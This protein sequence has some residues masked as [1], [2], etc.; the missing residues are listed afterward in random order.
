MRKILADV[1]ARYGR[2][3]DTEA[4]SKTRAYLEVL[5]SAAKQEDLAMFGIAY[6][7]QLHNPDRRYTGW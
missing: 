2:D 6:L 7:D 5:V 3:V 4:L 1:V